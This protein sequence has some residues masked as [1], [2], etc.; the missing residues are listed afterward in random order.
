MTEPDAGSDAFGS[1]RTTA[2][3]DGDSFVLNGQ[4]TFITNAPYADTFI[5]YAKLEGADA[6]AEAEEQELIGRTVTLTPE[7]GV[8]QA[9]LS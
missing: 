3:R 2:R 5:V 7:N 9:R 1:M 8:N 6:W 4:K